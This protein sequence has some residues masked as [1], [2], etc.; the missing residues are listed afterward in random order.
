[1]RNPNLNEINRL[2]KKM[3]Q[4]ANNWERDKVYCRKCKYFNIWFSKDLECFNNI[5]FEYSEE[6]TPIARK[7]VKERVD[8]CYTLNKN[9]NCKYFKKRMPFYL[10]LIL[11]SIFGAMLTFFVFTLISWIRY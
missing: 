8:G 10:R 5:C 3:E 6:D 1:M 2:L 9:N 7:I 4:A 11:S